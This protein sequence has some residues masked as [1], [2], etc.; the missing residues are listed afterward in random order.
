MAK[1]HR[2]FVILVRGT[3]EINALVAVSHAVA[4]PATQTTPA[5]TT[6]HLT[7]V[8]LD[9]TAEGNSQSGEGLRNSVRI[10]IDVPPVD[11]GRHFGWK[12]VTDYNVTAPDGKVYPEVPGSDGYTHG[13]DKG[14]AGEGDPYGIYEYTDQSANPDAA[15]PTQA[16]AEELA[17]KADQ[18]R[19]DRAAEATGKPEVS[20]VKGPDGKTDAERGYVW[21]SPEHM[22]SLR[23]DPPADPVVN[24]AP[25]DPEL[26]AE[27]TGMAPADPPAEPTA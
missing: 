9:P 7:L 19:A 26:V 18:A 22:A 1:Q 11:N 2:D 13:W 4:T 10:Q 27:Q 8:Y 24:D 20:T 17:A 15:H 16:Q 23:T 6:E 3:E 12:D 21:G 14:F 25:A 5:F